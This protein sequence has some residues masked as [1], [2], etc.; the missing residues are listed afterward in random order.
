MR[1]RDECERML[2][3]LDRWNLRNIKQPL[4]LHWHC[5]ISPQT[6]SVAPLRPENTVSH[7]IVWV[8]MKDS[9]LI[10]ICPILQHLLLIT[11]AGSR[12]GCASIWF[13]SDFTK[14]ASIWHGLT[15][16]MQHAEI[17]HAALSSTLSPFSQFSL[18][19]EKHF[20]EKLNL[21]HSNDSQTRLID[22]STHNIRIR[23]LNNWFET[24]LLDW[25]KYWH[26]HFI[27]RAVQM[28]VM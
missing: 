13:T 3:C 15:V 9:V 28:E 21:W 12:G 25:G 24:C 22:N 2:I 11:L 6:A 26:T 1:H 10:S 8:H 18:Q 23:S 20:F 5:Y 19:I 17:T 7:Q 16:S 14:L 4:Q 27:C